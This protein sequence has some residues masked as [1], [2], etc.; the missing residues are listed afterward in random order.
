VLK[1]RLG[2]GIC[3][4]LLGR[5]TGK[6][7]RE[8]ANGLLPQ[9]VIQQTRAV[10]F[11]LVM[12]LEPVRDPVTFQHVVEGLTSGNEPALRF[13]VGNDADGRAPAEELGI[14]LR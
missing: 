4:S 10:D 1:I 7:L 9:V 6:A 12:Y 2:R 11:D 14:L 8:E 5:C 3:A 13:I